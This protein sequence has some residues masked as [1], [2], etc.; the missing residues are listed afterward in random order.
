[1]DVPR[2]QRLFGQ[3]AELYLGLSDTLGFGLFLRTLAGGSVEVG[4]DGYFD[5]AIAELVAPITGHVASVRSAAPGDQRALA[6]AQQQAYA[7]VAAC[8]DPRIADLYRDVLR[9]I[10]ERSL[11]RTGVIPV[12]ALGTPIHRFWACGADL[13]GDADR[14][15]TLVAHVRA[16]CAHYAETM[17][18]AQANTYL[19][20]NA[21]VGVDVGDIDIS[22]LAAFA[23]F[24]FG[25]DT[26]FSLFDKERLDPVAMAPVEV[27]LRFAAPRQR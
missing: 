26:T 10:A 23:C 22:G 14:P 4:T 24:R 8:G 13:I 6:D 11:H 20:R 19:W 7:F 5:Q 12:G 9:A 1:V 16:M 3:S 17:Q 27:G 2:A 25:P 21:A 15:T 18:L